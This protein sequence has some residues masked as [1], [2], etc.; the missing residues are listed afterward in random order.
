MPTEMPLHLAAQNDHA[1]VIKMLLAAGTNKENENGCTPRY[2]AAWSGHAEVIEMLFAANANKDATN[3]DGFT[4]SH[5]A[6]R[7]W[8]QQGGG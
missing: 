5:F 3:R 7:S 4:P 8:G 2:L 1:E 6:P